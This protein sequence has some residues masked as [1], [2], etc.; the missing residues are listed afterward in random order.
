MAASPY[1]PSLDEL[2]FALASALDDTLRQLANYADYTPDLC[3][4][5]LEEAAKF[6]QECL[7]PINHSGDRLGSRRNA[8]GTVT[9]PPGFVEAYRDFCASGW[10]AAPISTEYGGQGLPLPLSTLVSEMWHGANMSFG[11]CPM[12]TQSAIELIAHHASPEL[13]A[14]YLPKLVSGEWSG[15]MCMTEPQAGSD[16][17]AVRTTASP[18]GECF[19]I[20]GTKIFITYGEHDMSSNIIHMV[21]ARLPGAPHGTRG[22]SLFLVP[23]FLLNEDG[24]PGT[25]NDLSCISLE[26]KMGINASPTCIMSF[27]DNGGA[28]GYLVGEANK[29]VHAMFTMMNKAR[30]A[31]GLEGIGIMGYAAQLAAEYAQSRQQGGKDIA[32]FG[33]VERMLLTLQSHH[34]AMRALA[35]Y[36]AAQM[37]VASYHPDDSACITAQDRVDLLIPVIKAHGTQLGFDMASLSM[38]VHG[39]LGYIEETGISQLMR[40]V[41]VAMI[42][43]GTNGIQALDLIGRKLQ[44]HDGRLADGLIREMKDYCTGIQVAG[45]CPPNIKLLGD[46]INAIEQ[47]I[48]LINTAHKDG[49][50][51]ALQR[52]ADSFLQ[53]FGLT[54]EGYMLLRAAVDAQRY[55]TLEG[56][57]GFSPAL[58]VGKQ[59]LWNFFACEILIGTSLHATRIAQVLRQK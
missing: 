35:C 26:H 46:A 57:N 23:K 48:N 51:H 39:G 45:I 3:N 19:R 20:K 21:L 59:R 27:G 6:A 25:A 4:S 49:N 1:T 50:Q 24:S 47:S 40:D 14:L 58:L 9:T 42:Y 29:G 12:L 7:N 55:A 16:V 8:D 38:Q 15:T 36:V 10:N 53:L 30:F 5:I 31:V 52:A 54:A 32:T 2:R 34:Q 43:E 56:M 41:R 37:D 28:I 44:L 11:L 17:G 22:V 33:D 13:Q 18:E